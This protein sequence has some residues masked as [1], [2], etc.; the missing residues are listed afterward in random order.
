MAVITGQWW[1]GG[2]QAGLGYHRVKSQAAEY[3]SQGDREVETQQEA[4]PQVPLG[5][6]RTD[7]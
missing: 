4:G 2:G 1:G 3:L 6:I 5:P 7:I